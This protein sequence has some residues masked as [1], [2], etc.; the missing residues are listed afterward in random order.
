MSQIHGQDKVVKGT[1]EKMMSRPILSGLFVLFMVLFGSTSVGA[2]TTSKTIPVGNSP[3]AVAVNATTNTIYVANSHSNSVSVIDGATNTV[4]A[5][6]AVGTL[7]KGVAVDP[8]TNTVYVTNAGS[9]SVS[10]I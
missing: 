3:D 7:P 5:T 4:T 8:A 9:N 2:N 10:V 6:I 1:K